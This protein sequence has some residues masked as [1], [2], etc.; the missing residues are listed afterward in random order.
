M[1]VNLPAIPRG[2]VRCVGNNAIEEIQLPIRVNLPTIPV[3][4][5][6]Y[7][8]KNGIEAIPTQIE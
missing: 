5:V 6:L 7:V 8:G 1:R 4:V 3:G 2:V